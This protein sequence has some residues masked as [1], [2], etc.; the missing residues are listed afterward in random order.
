MQVVAAAT[1]TTQNT[2]DAEAW[3]R[4]GAAALER[5]V[6]RGCSVREAAASAA[7]EL[8]RGSGGWNRGVNSLLLVAA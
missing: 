2:D 1:R 6:V 5:L 4:A 8:E 7:E 3:A